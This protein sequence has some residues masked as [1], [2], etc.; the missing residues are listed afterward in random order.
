MSVQGHDRS[1]TEPP[2]P[3]GY[4]AAADYFPLYLFLFILIPGSPGI[5]YFY[6]LIPGSPGDNNEWGTSG[7]L[8]LSTYMMYSGLDEVLGNRIL[9]YAIGPDRCLVVARCP[10]RFV[11]A[12]YEPG[13]IPSQSPR[14]V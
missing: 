8:W 13:V 14:G 3:V 10:R 9:M 5:L 2:G 7:P 1:Q 11:Y 4:P 12:C 6:F